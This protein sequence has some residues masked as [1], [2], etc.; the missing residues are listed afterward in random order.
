M[1]S[2][3][4]KLPGSQMQLT[5]KLE[6]KEFSGYYQAAEDKAA[7]EVTIKG[8]RKGA[9]PKE[10]VAA[11]LNHD[12]I[13]HDAINEAVRW[14]LNE[15]K[16][17]NT[18][19]F[20]DQPKI[21]VTSGEPGKGIEYKATLTLFPEITMGDYK[22]TATKIFSQKS[23]VVVTDE[24]IN[25]TLEWLRGSRAK[26]T[27]VARGAAQK[28]LVE[29]DVETESAGVPVPNATFQNERFI[30]GESSFITGFDRA[31]EGKKENEVVKFSIV[32]PKDYWQK[33][34]QEKQL[35][36]TVVIRGVFERSVPELN[37]E[38]AQSLGSKFK[39]AE[40]LKTNIREGL[41]MEKT[42]KELE[43]K[44]IKALD[45]IAKDSKMDLPAILIER[46]LEGMVADVTR[47]VPPG[48]NK[49]PDELAKEMREKL[50]D[51][52]KTNVAANLVMYKLAQVEKLEPTAEEIG[53]EATQRGVDLEKEHDY[54]YGTLQNKKIFAFLE[55]QGAK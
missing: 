41:T 12:E 23:E 37:D 17:E 39:T 7:A 25:K 5:V 13:F 15:I 3:I 27:R 38:F 18:W 45:E 9:A 48:E 31:L 35:D 44:R 2:D 6:D 40:D 52:A 36:F 34:L 30:L 28:D 55:A 46:T 24:E 49:K 16:M 50:R 32:A 47:M 42:E 21:E 33:E 53:A 8:F 29:I 10:M 19:T 4:K 43:K 1:K 20:I 11:G 51:R 54:I 22:K 26:E 14:S